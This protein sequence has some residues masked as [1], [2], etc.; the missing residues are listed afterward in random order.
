M[1]LSRKTGKEFPL[2]DLLHMN[3]NSQ[4]VSRPRSR[5]GKPSKG[6]TSGQVYSIFYSCVLHRCL[7]I[8]SEMMC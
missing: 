7:C 2:I 3:R 8:R 6:S 1:S 5:Q 4:G